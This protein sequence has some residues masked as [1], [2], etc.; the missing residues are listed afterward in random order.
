MNWEVGEVLLVDKPLHW[1]SF[2]VVNK[3][4]YSISRKA[5]KRMKV[6]HAGTLDPLA[7]GLLIICAGKMTKRIDEFTGMEKEYTGTF[8]LGATTPTY[9]SETQPD[10]LFPTDHITIEQ[11]H[12][13]KEQFTGAIAQIPPVYSAIKVDGK[14]AYNQARKGKDIELKPRDILIHELEFTRI[15]LPEVDFRVT[16][17][18]GTYIR[19]L[20]FDFGKA[21]QS[22]AYLKAL[23]RT[24]IGSFKLEDASSV[25]EWVAKIQE[26]PQD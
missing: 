11:L 1:T 4:R 2:D 23:T 7:T 19:S 13:V 21:L 26:D 16:C 10:K 12:A 3:L 6:G 15:Q 17:S 8:M 20:A 9:D 18:K 22:G 24:R 14:V 25:E 5:G